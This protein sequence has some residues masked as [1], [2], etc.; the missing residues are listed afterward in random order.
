MLVAQSPLAAIL[1]H[2]R[3]LVVQLF[4]NCKGS[5]MSLSKKIMA[6]CIIGFF[7]SACGDGGSV[8]GNNAGPKK[9]AWANQM[10]SKLIN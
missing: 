8:F 3:Q 6:I 10:P 7:L 5:F 9:P 2:P 4:S 1:P